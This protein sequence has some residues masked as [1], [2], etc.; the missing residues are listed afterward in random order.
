MLLALLH[1]CHHHHHTHLSTHI[2]RLVHTHLASQEM[3]Q[4]KKPTLVCF[5][6]HTQIQHHAE[7]SQLKLAQATSI[8]HFFTKHT[9]NMS[10]AQLAWLQSMPRDCSHLGCFDKNKDL[11][12]LE[13]HLNVMRFTRHKRGCCIFQSAYLKRHNLTELQG[14]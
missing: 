14:N 6:L 8:F 13:N 12:C 11:F 7:V 2:W 4:S 5:F 10:K 1:T 9:E 3:M